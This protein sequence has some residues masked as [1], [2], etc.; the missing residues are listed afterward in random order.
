MQGK[1]SPPGQACGNPPSSARACETSPR[2]HFEAI[3]PRLLLSGDPVSL[4]MATIEAAGAHAEVQ[5]HDATLAER[6]RVLVDRLAG[7]PPLDGSAICQA[8]ASH[9]RC[10]PRWRNAGTRSLEARKSLSGG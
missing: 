3:E 8:V 2:I 4:P 7:N 6:T 9:W 5:S 10:L 1:Q